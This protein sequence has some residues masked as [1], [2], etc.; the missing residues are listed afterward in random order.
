MKTSHLEREAVNASSQPKWLIGVTLVTAVLG[1]LL[2]AKSNRWADDAR[3]LPRM[4]CDDLVQNGPGGSQFIILTDVRLCSRGDAFRRDMDADMEMY[5]P[6]YSTR[7]IKEPQPENLKLLLQVLDDRERDRL[8]ARPEVHELMVEL[9]TSTGKLYPWVKDRLAALYPGIQL[10]NCRVLS[11]G[12]HEPSA[13]RIGSA[14]QEGVA[15]IIVAFGCQV[16]WL[17]WKFGRTHYPIRQLD[18]CAAQDERQ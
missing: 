3:S 18:V 1:V 9:W 15:L 5:V 16:G 6:I 10:A 8:L 17:I 14:M 4:T 12:L 2:I 13:L 11:V 7:L